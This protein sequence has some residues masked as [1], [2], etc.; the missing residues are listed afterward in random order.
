MVKQFRL[1]ITIRRFGDRKER[2]TE[3]M[4]KKFLRA[5]I[6]HKKGSFENCLKIVMR[7][8]ISPLDYVFSFVLIRLLPPLATTRS[9]VKLGALNS[10]ISVR[11]RI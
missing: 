8:I 11:K 10:F 9:R 3:E 6:I 4:D 1:L 5:R 7:L 2:S